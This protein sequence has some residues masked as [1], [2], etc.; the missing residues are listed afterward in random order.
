[1]APRRR[2]GKKLFRSFLPIWLVLALAVVIALAS[3][4]Y[5]IS[6][7]PRR[8]YLVT[9]EAFSQISGPVLRITDE[10]WR[11]RDGTSARGW[12]LRGTPGA[13]AV[14]FLHRYGADRSWLFN[15]GVKLNETANFTILWPDLRGHGLNPPVSWTSFG[16]RE[17]D[18]L[19]AALDFLRMLKGAGTTRLIGDHIGLYG[20]EL[21]A[22]TALLGA[23]HDTGVEV[24]VLDSVPGNADDLLSSALRDHIGIDNKVLRYLARGA[25][26]IYFVGKYQNASSCQ[27]AASLKVRRVLLLSGKDAGSLRNSTMA[28]G[29]CFP[30][31]QT[32]EAKTDLPLTGFNLTSGTGEQGDFYDR[33]VIDFF[34]RNLH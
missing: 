34:D 1:M 5:G 12:L 25:I 30:D 19:L 10:T 4:I 31:Q 26:R 20:V 27:L 28:L 7:P 17:G 14:I 21:G 23:S 8:P 3:I 29:Q 6:R 22:Y 2:I 18:D 13:P 24:L 11:N 32:V 16:T 33:Q 9:P 15:L